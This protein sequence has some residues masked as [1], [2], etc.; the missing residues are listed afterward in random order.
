MSWSTPDGRRYAAA[1]F[2]RPRSLALRLP[3]ADAAIGREARAAV[4]PLRA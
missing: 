3:K 4:G 2:L 1:V